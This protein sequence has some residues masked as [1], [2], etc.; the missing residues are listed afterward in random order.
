MKVAIVHDD[1]V[2]WGGGE[3]VLEGLCEA[4]PDAPIYTSVFNRNNKE[5]LQRFGTKKIITSFLQQIPGWEKIYKAFLPLYPIAF[6]QFDFSQFDL[7]ISQTTRFAKCII[8]KPTTKH[9]CYMHTPPRFLWNF[10]REV[11]PA[12]LR[13]YFKLMSNWDRV[14]AQRP[15][16]YLAGSKNA[17][18]RIKQVYNQDSKI[19][20]PF[21]DF[22]RFADCPTFDGDYFVV[23]AR[24]NSYKR[25]DL[26]IKACIQSKKSLKVIGQG[27][28]FANLKAL[29]AP[30]TNIQLL[31]GVNDDILKYILSG[32][33]A[34]IIPGEEDFGLSSLEAQ[35]LGKPVIAFRSGGALETVLE[36]KTGL[37][38]DTQSVDNLENVLDAFRADSFKPE[39]CKTNARRFDR[40]TFIRSIKRLTL[41][42]S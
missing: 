25:V 26:A 18:N 31:G 34:L 36:Q 14:W 3:R 22:K 32:A 9:I 8:T 19:L 23:I 41:S 27:S 38:F 29:A 21:I 13:S 6:E 11:Q 39:D 40:E 35:A 42:S 7:V 33:S 12:V 4:F 20:Y 5:L 1:L 24:L 37:F 10:S 2:Q 28:E 15:D 17:S 16:M 30:H